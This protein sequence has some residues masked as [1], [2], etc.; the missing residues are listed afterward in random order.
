VKLAE[1]V[2][3]NLAGVYTKQSDPIERAVSLGGNLND[4]I[5][6]I[7]KQVVQMKDATNTHTTHSTGP[8]FHAGH[9]Y[10]GAPDAGAH[11]GDSM[12]SISILL[13]LCLKLY[14]DR[15]NKRR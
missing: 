2:R 15:R 12:V 8:E 9:S 14:Q 10:P 4:F 3:E 6:S 5:K 7:D 13:G 11:L 1:K